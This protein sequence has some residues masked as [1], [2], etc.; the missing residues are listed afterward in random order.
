[1]N[2]SQSRLSNVKLHAIES[3]DDAQNF[4]EWARARLDAEIACDTESTGFKWHGAD[5]VRM[6]QVGDEDDGWA[7]RWDRWSGLFESFMQSHTGPI[8]MMNAKFDYP[9]LRKMGIELDKS[10]IRDVG[11]MSHILEPHMSRALKNQ[12]KRHVD[13]QADALQAALDE[14]FAQ[15]WTWATVPFDFDPYRFYAALDP[16]LTALVREHHWPLVQEQAPYAYEIENAFQWVALKAETYGVHVDVDYA[17]AHFDKFTRYCEDVEKWC[18][19]EYSVSPG[20]NQA[21]IRILADAGVEFSKTTK[22]GALSLDSDV[23]EGVDH[24]LAQQVLMRRRLQKIANTYLKFYVEHADA[25][26]LIYPSINTLGARTGRMSVAE[27]NFQNLPVRGGHAGIKTVRSSITARP[28]HTLVFC[29][30]DQIEMRGMAILSGDRGLIDAFA[31]PED[32][33][34]TIARNIYQ[35][36]TLVKSD[37]RRQPTKNSLYARIY[38]AGITKQ[39]ATAG[40]SY[41]QMA[42]VNRALNLAYP[43][44]ESFSNRIISESVQQGYVSCPLT[45]RR[46]YPDRGKDYAQVNYLIQGWAASVFKLKALELDA[47]GLGEY[48]TGFIHDEFMFDIPTEDVP[49]AVHT[50]RKIM[51]DDQMFPVPIS[52]GVATGPSWGDKREWVEE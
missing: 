1:M 13:P 22:G 30:L 24:P 5:Y 34:V 6:V 25:S 15:G 31:Q 9:F 2:S 16:V 44:I 4:T 14:G 52:A 45:G 29:D 48:V 50:I 36:P 38:G 28:G 51:N 49:D 27:P 17:R 46:H 21:V 33:F 40:V 3:L 42:F 20:S 47:A 23:L 12:A 7:M 35:D 43:G 37:P 41:D 18:K 19:R 10:R 39:A 32:F 11:V 26:G 8:D